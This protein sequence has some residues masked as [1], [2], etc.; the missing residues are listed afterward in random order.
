MKLY[1]P[2]T[3]RGLRKFDHMLPIHAV[4]QAWT[5]PGNNPEYHKQAQEMVRRSMPLLA[6][7]LDRLATRVPY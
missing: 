6:R 3:W 1:T 2:V 7:A 4:V 5:N